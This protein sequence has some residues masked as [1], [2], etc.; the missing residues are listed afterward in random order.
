MHPAF[1]RE[2]KARVLRAPPFFMAGSGFVAAPVC[3]V[4]ERSGPRCQPSSCSRHPPGRGE[5]HDF[6]R[7][8]LGV[9]SVGSGDFGGAC[10]VRLRSRFLRQGSAAP[11][12]QPSAVI[13]G[14]SVERSETASR[15]PPPAVAILLHRPTCDGSCQQPATRPE[16]GAR[17]TGARAGAGRS[18]HIVSYGPGRSARRRFPKP[19]EAGSTPAA[20]A[21]FIPLGV[22]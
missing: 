8:C 11:S 5:C 15:R 7:G 12:L 16:E 2:R 13:T 22:V 9:F 6:F 3:D 14:S 20:R 19:A 18:F 17:S 4:I 21:V 10:C 1:N